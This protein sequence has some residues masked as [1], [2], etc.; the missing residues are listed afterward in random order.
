ML[1]KQI[2][3]LLALALVLA[4]ALAACAAPAT[5]PTP[6]AAPNP[7]ATTAPAKPAI[8][9]VILATTTSTRDSGLLDVLIPDFEKKTGHKV[10]M[11]AVGSGAAIALGERGEADV[12]LV[13]S[14]A[15]EVAFM[16]AGHGTKRL[17]VMHNDF[18]IV[19]PK[20]DAAGIKSIPKVA[21]AFKAIAAKGSLFISRGDASGTDTAEKNVWKA[22]GITAKG[23]SWYQETGQGMGETLKVA[24]EKDAYTMTD[25]AT[26][27]ATQKNLGLGL[28]MEGDPVL[29]NIYHVIPVD[30]KKNDK[31]NA[32]GGE[33]FAQ[34][35][36]AP[37]TQKLIGTF[38]V[39]KYGG[40]LFFPDASKKESDLGS[41]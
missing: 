17:L 40:A 4:L 25:R 11:I 31:M 19:G 39:E 15:A 29:L 33:A 27:L 13:H 35:M 5:A 18:V 9:E 20:S 41:Q 14:P 34:Y 32:P 30:P 8:V 24:S 1:R 7:A 3:S 36:V 10:K 28:L 38:G 21:D 37:D 26:W 2:G 12:L 16:N 23:Q 6:T 22:A